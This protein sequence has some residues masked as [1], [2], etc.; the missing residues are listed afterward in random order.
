ME[1]EKEGQRLEIIMPLLSASHPF[2]SF[3]AGGFFPLSRKIKKAF[4]LDFLRSLNFNELFS[5]LAAR[6]LLTPYWARDQKAQRAEKGG[7]RQK[8]ERGKPLLSF[9][10]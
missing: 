10:S 7:L 1:Q 3:V 2:Y 6:L 4:S 5:S 9:R 8:K